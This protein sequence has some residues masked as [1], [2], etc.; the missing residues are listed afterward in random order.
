MSFDHRLAIGIVTAIFAVMSTPAL[1]PAPAIDWKPFTFTSGAGDTLTADSARITVPENRARSTGRTIQIAVM[2]IRSTATR[3]GAPIIYLAGG[4]GG[5]GISGAR[6]ELFP[7]VLALRGVSD[8][9]LFDQRGTGVTLP[10]LVTRRTFGVPL[11]VSSTS[12]E[13]K[14][15]MIDNSRAAAEEV[16]ARGID[17][18]AYN[19][20][21]N[22]DDI[23]DIRQ[24]LG[25]E[26]LIVWGHSYGSHLGL[27]YIR[28]HGAHV[29]RA[30]L[31]GINGPD[32]RRRFPKDGDVLFA[33]LDSLIKATPSLR[34]VMPDFLGTTRRVLDRLA[35]Q[36][37]TVTVD[38]QP[39]LVG[40]EDV[41]SV[42][43][44]SSGEAAFVRRLP[45]LIGQMDAGN[46]ATMGRMV[47]D[48]IKNRPLGTVMTY[49]TDLAS[50]VSDE[51]MRAIRAQVPGAL[52]G[53]AIN[54][55]F[56]DPE[57]Q[58]AWGAPDLGPGFRTP[59]RSNV[60]TLFLS[61]TL[62][63]RTSLSDAEEIRR[64]FTRGLR[65]DVNNASHNLYAASPALLDIMVRFARGETVR[66]VTLDAV[67]VELR[68]PDEQ[69]L[70]DELRAI[71]AK[72]GVS[73]AANRLREAAKPG[74]GHHVTG[75]FVNDLVIA[76][77]RQDRAVAGA[78][79]VAGLELFPGNSQLLTRRAE[80]E[81]AAG[82]TAAAIESYRAAI[83]A[84][85]FNQVAG[86]Q[87]RRLEAPK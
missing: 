31:G 1:A 34:A 12:A 45:Q 69:P 28:R 38:S 59:I 80:G 78:F 27:T 85:A 43:A 36:P 33:R 73:A 71:I 57:F 67:N 63:G 29:D 37:A 79:L 3:P 4:P 44:I 16:R 47:R 66:T 64:G 53:N 61:G 62:D 87:L 17:L 42:I 75:A 86:V 21:E 19:T 15:A 48:V 77:A 72:D 6:G 49:M 11:A 8:V 7:T 70:V 52:L 76:F 81:A 54:Y 32:H 18:T 68:G 51:R 2:R 9:I 84:D 41:Q 83:K 30:I 10:S 40:K 50:G 58:A 56:D 65:V 39:V 60:P 46:F 22:A 82:N 55:P 74:S 14:K 20:N 5:A 25:V 26:R 35:Q 24:A 13:A 23:D